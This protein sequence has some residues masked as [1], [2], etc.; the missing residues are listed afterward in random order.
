[1]KRRP[2]GIRG[3]A[4]KWEIRRGRIGPKKQNKKETGEKGGST[5]R[6][7]TNKMT[8]RHGK[9]GAERTEEKEDN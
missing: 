6:G 9:R 8:A 2:K 5:T 4:Q 1:M 3:G 7:Q